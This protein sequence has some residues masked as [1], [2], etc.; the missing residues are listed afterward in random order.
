MRDT[1]TCLQ[2]LA[3]DTG[4]SGAEVMTMAFQTGMRQ[5]WR[6]H[7]LGQYLRSVISRDE[8]IEMVGIDWV[9]LVERQRKAMMEDIAW[10]MEG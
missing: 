9:E 10:A 5:L 4:K 6:E 8:A 3:R 2:I 7:V 1:L